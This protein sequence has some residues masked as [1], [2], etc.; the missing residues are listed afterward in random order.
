VQERS[1]LTDEGLN[2]QFTVSIGVALFPDHASSKKAVIDAADKAMYSAKKTSRNSVF[3]AAMEGPAKPSV[4]KPAPEPERPASLKAGLSPVKAV[5][6]ARG[7]G[8]EGAGGA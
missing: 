5:K 3:I 2:L 1:F 8:Q 7:H 4:V 6:P